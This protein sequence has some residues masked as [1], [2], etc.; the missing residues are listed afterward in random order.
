[1]PSRNQRPSPRAG[2]LGQLEMF[3]TP[4]KCVITHILSYQITLSEAQAELVAVERQWCH[5]PQQS[6]VGGQGG[7]ITE[8]ESLFPETT[9]CLKWRG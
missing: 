7:R 8:R 1:M 6:N 3:L 9:G 4:A 2:L 5:M